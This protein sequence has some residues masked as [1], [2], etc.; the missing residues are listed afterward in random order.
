MVWFEEMES[1]IPRGSVRTRFAPSPT[2]YMHVGGLRTAL[3]AYLVAKKYGGTFIL[4]IEDT[5]AARF[6]E[7]ATEIIIDTLRGAGLHYDEGPDIGGPAG[8]YTQS[9][10]KHLYL[11]YAKLLCEKGAAYYCFCEDKGQ[12]AGNKE[13]GSWDDAESGEASEPL[14]GASLSHFTSQLTDDPCRELPFE[15]SK[16]RV[17]MGE[18]H[19]VRM[20]A[21]REGSTTVV[22]MVFGEITA[23]RK[24]V[25]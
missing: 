10:R 21:P 15:E 5:D 14:G 18:S 4:R 12:K 25:V 17:D 3:Y 19:I 6:V 11:P 22:D 20:K 8:P 13:H 24:S 1:K 16:R 2:G 9:E 23:D 7:G